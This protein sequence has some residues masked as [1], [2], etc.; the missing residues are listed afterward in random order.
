MQKNRIFLSI[1][2]LAFLNS[3]SH[4]LVNGSS[5]AQRCVANSG[6]ACAAV[7]APRSN[8][9]LKLTP[10]Q[11]ALKNQLIFLSK[12]ESKWPEA[13][14]TL[15]SLMP[16]VV[17]LSAENK[18]KPVLA[19]VGQ[20]LFEMGK[21]PE[22]ITKENL[23][24]TIN[25]LAEMIDNQFIAKGLSEKSKHKYVSWLEASRNIE[26]AVLKTEVPARGPDSPSTLENPVFLKE[27]ENL[28]AAK[29]R[30]ASESTLLVD[31]PQS[32]PMRRKLIEE[33][34]KSVY[35]MT[36][37]IEN[38]VTGWQFAKQLVEKYKAGVDVKIIVDHKTAQQA[39]YGTVPKWLEE[40]GVNLIYW[41]DPEFPFFAFHKK[42][43]ITDGKYLVAGGMN[44]GDVYSHMGSETTPRWRDTDFYTT[45]NPAI[46]TQSIFIETWNAMIEKNNLSLPKLV[47]ELKYIAPNEI[48]SD[49]KIMVIDQIPNPGAKDKIL[50]SVIKGIEGATKEINIENAY[51]IRNPAMHR[52]LIRAIRRGVKVRIFTNSTTSID[53]PI[54]A[55]PILS[56]LQTLFKLAAGIFLKKGATLH[57]KFMTVDGVASWVMS[58]NH[59][60][61]SM[62]IQGEIAYIIL[63]N[64]FTNNLASQFQIDVS[65]IATNVKSI[66]ELQPKETF[67]DLLLRHY[68]F[69]QL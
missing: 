3:C 1:I 33:A 20:K 61:Q 32:F 65:T 55:K 4:S 9:Q 60:P 67:I 7:F 51:F 16:M 13:I 56:S 38:D 8:A 22:R 21:L 59:H 43:L 25:L 41:K 31:G 14:K 50:L 28:T 69:D 45:G 53:V 44:F 62:R 42:A 34:K 63:G 40:Q 36:W 15:D 23:P 11:E 46:E 27:L 2:S 54:I 66:E 6:P 52:A 68:F 48:K 30:E 12:D 58:Y 64:K 5:P 18:L 49:S 26:K 39:I 35:V 29:F 47:F 24:E 57:S 10:E 19:N 37:A 17:K